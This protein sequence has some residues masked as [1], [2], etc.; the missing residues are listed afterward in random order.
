MYVNVVVVDGKQQTAAFTSYNIMLAPLIRF[1]NTCFVYE[2]PWT[3]WTSVVPYFAVDQHDSWWTSL[4]VDSKY[5][6]VVRNMVI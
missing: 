1:T 5:Q 2:R 4:N 3:R 6:D